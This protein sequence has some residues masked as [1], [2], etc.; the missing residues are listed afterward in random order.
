MMASSWDILLLRMPEFLLA[1]GDQR[2]TILAYVCTADGA[3]Q[4]LGAMFTLFRLENTIQN[5]FRP[6]PQMIFHENVIERLLGREI[7]NAFFQGYG[8][9]PHFSHG[10]ALVV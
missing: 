10:R 9:N 2:E 5:N 8:D 6:I 7:S 3:L 1:Q 4:Q